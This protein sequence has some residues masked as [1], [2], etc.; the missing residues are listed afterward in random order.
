[1]IEIHANVSGTNSRVGV[2]RV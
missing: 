1:L 2:N